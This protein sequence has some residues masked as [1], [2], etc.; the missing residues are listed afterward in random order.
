MV[1]SFTWKHA[2][3]RWFS[4][5]NWTDVTGQIQVQTAIMS[6]NH[7]PIMLRRLITQQQVMQWPMLP[8]FNNHNRNHNRNHNHNHNRNNNNSN[9]IIINTINRELFLSLSFFFKF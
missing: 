8:K 9:I 2:V 6:T 3:H 4:Q 5:K 1:Q 7:K